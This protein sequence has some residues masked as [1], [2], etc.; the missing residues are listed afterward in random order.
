MTTQRSKIRFLIKQNTRLK[1]RLLGTRIGFY[2]FFSIIVFISSISLGTFNVYYFFL[3]VFNHF[4]C[5]TIFIAGFYILIGSK[6]AIENWQVA[7][8]RKEDMFAKLQLSLFEGALFLVFQF[9]LFGIFYLTGLPKTYEQTY[10]SQFTGECPI[11]YI[12]TYQEAIIYGFIIFLTIISLFTSIFWLYSRCVTFTGFNDEE[13][14]FKINPTK[15]LLAIVGNFIIWS[16]F[17]PIF[18]DVAFF[19]GAGLVVI[20]ASLFVVDVVKGNSEKATPQSAHR[21][22]KVKSS[23]RPVTFTPTFMVGANGLTGGLVGRF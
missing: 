20:G 1:N 15:M 21:T 10:L 14:L 22:D 3:N 2:V 12:P 4:V 13:N 6:D 11:S 23:D 18:F 9:I 5:F 16:V 8:L 19:A 7:S 17:I